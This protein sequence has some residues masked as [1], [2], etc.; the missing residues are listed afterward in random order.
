MPSSTATDYTHNAWMKYLLRGDQFT[1]PNS[2][3]VALFTTVPGPSGA[4]GVE[5][6]TSG[7]AY[8]RVEIVKGASS[9][10]GPSGTNLEYSN[11]NDINFAIPT[12]NWGTIT[13]AGLFDAASGG[14]LMY[15]STLVTPKTVNQGDGAPRILATQLRI[16]R[17]TC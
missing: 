5:V 8:A 13:G 14:N 4:G 10:A 17:A 2:L 15:Y 7:T 1:P 9:W 11:A 16:S 6:S 12:G 3:W